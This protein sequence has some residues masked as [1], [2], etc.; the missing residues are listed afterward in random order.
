MRYADHLDRS[1]DQLGRDTWESQLTE[2]ESIRPITAKAHAFCPHCRVALALHV[3]VAVSPLPTLNNS[4][5]ETLV[6]LAAI[7][8]ADIAFASRPEPLAV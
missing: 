8:A 2:A 1:M 4:A 7:T 3:S 5:D 6:E